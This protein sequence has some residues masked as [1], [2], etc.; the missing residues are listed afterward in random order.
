MSTVTGQQVFA[1]A[2][3]LIHMICIDGPPGTFDTFLRIRQNKSR[4]VIA[5]PDPSCYDS[6]QTLMTLREIDHQN[7]ITSDL[8]TFHYLLRPCHRFFRHILPALIQ[9]F[10]VSCQY[11]RLFLILRS[12]KTQRSLCRVKPSGGIHTR[13]QNK[14]D[15]ISTDLISLNPRTLYQGAESGTMGTSKHPKAFLYKDSVLT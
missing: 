8:R 15:M 1:F 3:F 7:L 11:I 5:L 2:E 4:F 14:T 12:Q 10:Q 9:R 13:P 6:R